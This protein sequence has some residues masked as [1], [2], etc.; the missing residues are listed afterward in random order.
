MARDVTMACSRLR[1]ATRCWAR[2]RGMDRTATCR[3]RLRSSSSHQ[4]FSGGAA[5][6]G[7]G[8]EA[9]VVTA[10]LV[11]APFARLALDLEGGFFLDSKAPCDAAA[12]PAVLPESFARL[13]SFSSPLSPPRASSLRFFAGACAGTG[14]FACCCANT[15]ARSASRSLRWTSCVSMHCWTWRGKHP[16][17]TALAQKEQGVSIDGFRSAVHTVITSSGADGRFSVLG[18]HENDQLTVV[19]LRPMGRAQWCLSDITKR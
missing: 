3:M 4:R 16:G 14:S 11:V 15:A 10:V 7:P 8:D 2:G 13:A 1:R 18:L 5:V 17:S 9:T 19:Q 12:P 6:A